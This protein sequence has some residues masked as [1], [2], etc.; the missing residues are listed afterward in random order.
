MEAQKKP[1]EDEK[2]RAQIWTALSEKGQAQTNQRAE[3]DATRAAKHAI[4]DA[5]RIYTDSEGSPSGIQK[6]INQKAAETSRTTRSK[7]ATDNPQV[8]KDA[9]NSG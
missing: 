1:H 5:M 8:D 9:D 7:T 3:L 2:L 4:R 6:I